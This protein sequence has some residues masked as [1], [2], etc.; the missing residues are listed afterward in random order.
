MQ[1][2]PNYSYPTKSERYCHIAEYIFDYIFKKEKSDFK[3][4][5]IHPNK[6]FANFKYNKKFNKKIDIKKVYFKFV[7]RDKN[8]YDFYLYL[9]EN[10]FQLIIKLSIIASSLIQ[11]QFTKLYENFNKLIYLILKLVYHYLSLLL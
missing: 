6:I 1:E 5:M 7:L 8:I 4:E 11:N 3:F 9:K 2:H 10:L